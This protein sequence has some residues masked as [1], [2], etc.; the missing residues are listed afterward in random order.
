MPAEI[1][2]FRSEF[3]RFFVDFPRDVEKARAL[4]R[5]MACGRRTGAV[6]HMRFATTA[7]AAC[8]QTRTPVSRVAWVSGLGKVRVQAFYEGYES[9]ARLNAA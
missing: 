6:M 1:I 4:G 7:L 8:A 2:A 5:L 9:L 3:A